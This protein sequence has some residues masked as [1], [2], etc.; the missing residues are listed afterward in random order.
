MRNEE[1]AVLRFRLNSLRT[2]AFLSARGSE[3]RASLGLQK[4]NKKENPMDSAQR[5]NNRTKAQGFSRIRSL[6]VTIFDVAI[7]IR[8]RSEMLRAGYS[9]CQVLTVDRS[10]HRG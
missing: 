10:V 6:L 3:Y 7:T 5:T 9:T 1:F 8:L 2:R 4:Q